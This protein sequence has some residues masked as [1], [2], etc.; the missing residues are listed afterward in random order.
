MLRNDGQPS[1]DRGPAPGLPSLTI[2]AARLQCDPYYTD[3]STYDAVHVYHQNVV[4][5]GVYD[6]QAIDQ[7]CDTA[8]ESSYSVPLELTTSVWGDVVGNYTTTPSGPPDGRVDIPADCTAILD[9]FKNLD[10][11]LTKVKCDLEPSRPDQVINI[12]DVTY[13]LDAFRGFEYPFEPW[14]DP[15]DRELSATPAASNSTGTAR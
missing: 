5:G 6:L 8:A 11:V 14:P 9:K 13:C 4:P 3:W 12:I 2:W 7:A 15:C 1:G 10:G